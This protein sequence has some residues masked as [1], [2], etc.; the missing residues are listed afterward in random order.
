MIRIWFQQIPGRPAQKKTA[1]GL[2]FIRRGGKIFPKSGMANI[3]HGPALDKNQVPM[4]DQ[5]HGDGCVAQLLHKLGVDRC[6]KPRWIGL[7]PRACPAL[8]EK[9]AAKSSLHKNPV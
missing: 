7:G 1:L 9:P 4:R 8:I 3:Q 2:T 6:E 5:G